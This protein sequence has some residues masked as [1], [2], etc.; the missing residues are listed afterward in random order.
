[1]IVP[2]NNT[3]GAFI[4]YSQ[5]SA[6]EE[7]TKELGRSHMLEPDTMSR[8]SFTTPCAECGDVVIAPE[9]SEHVSERYIRHL[10]SCEACGYEFETAVLPAGERSVSRVIGP[11]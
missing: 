1:M 7:R 4:I 6:Q 3:L 8:P 10:W 5:P 2:D 9:Q 11:L